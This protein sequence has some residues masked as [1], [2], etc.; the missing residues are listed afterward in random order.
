MS[1]IVLQDNRNGLECITYREFCTKIITDTEFRICLTPLLNFLDGLE[2]VQALDIE[3][4]EIDFRWAKLIMFGSYLRDLI[5][6]LDKFNLT[7][8]LPELKSYEME[9]LK[10]NPTLVANRSKFEKAYSVLF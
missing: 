2:G 3:T 4:K 10:E 9:Y 8:L 6:S 1:E 7:T 5:I